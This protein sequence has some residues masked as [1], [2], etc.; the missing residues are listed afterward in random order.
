MVLNSFLEEC[1]KRDGKVRYYSGFCETGFFEGYDSTN[2][3]FDKANVIRTQ[4]QEATWFHIPYDLEEGNFLKYLFY[5]LNNHILHN[6]ETIKKAAHNAILI[7]NWNPTFVHW[8]PKEKADNPGDPVIFS[9][10]VPFEGLQNNAF[11]HSRKPVNVDKLYKI[12]N[13]SI[14]N[15]EEFLI[16]SGKTYTKNL[17]SLETEKI[18]FEDISDR[19]DN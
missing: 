5:W 1:I 6:G 4:G 13:V 12:A 7:T 18:L 11:Y 15:P 8:W 2:H 19:L 14:E 3:I 16:P 17:Y 10:I 9:G